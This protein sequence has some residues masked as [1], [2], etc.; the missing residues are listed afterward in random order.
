MGIL[1]GLLLLRPTGLAGEEHG[2]D[3]AHSPALLVVAGRVRIV[4]SVRKR[5]LVRVLVA[6]GLAYPM[7]DQALGLHE[8]PVMTNILLFAILALGLNILLGFAGMLDLGYAAIFAIGGYTAAVLTDIGGPLAG[9]AFG[10]VDFMIVL[11]ASVALAGIFGAINGA[12]TLRLRGD[13]LAIVTLAFGQI[14]PLILLNLG[15]WTGGAQGMAGLPP[16]RLLTHSLRTPI[17]RYYL[18]L[19][20]LLIVAVGC[21][22]L[23]RSR[24]GRAW[25]ALSV[26]EAAALSCGV[27]IRSKLSAFV[28]GGAVAGIAGALFA[29][30]FSYVDSDQSD[31]AVTAMV[32]AMVI[33]GGAGSVRGAIIGAL[34]VAGYNQFVISQLGVWLDQIGKASGGALG[35][36]IAVFDLRELSHLFFGLALYLTILFRSRQR[37]GDSVVEHGKII[38]HETAR[39]D[40]LRR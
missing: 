16:P 2:E 38:P 40:P 1:I 11:L 6:V 39:P 27:P 15:Q 4:D 8:Q 9:G 25:A 14:V 21:Q 23:A 31:F 7:I 10:Q 3:L 5:W 20:V 29:G 32:L 37:A 18:A 17:E 28:L 22:R 34:V 19:A 13:Y 24:L 12:L 33:I 36:L 26:D 35:R 30:I